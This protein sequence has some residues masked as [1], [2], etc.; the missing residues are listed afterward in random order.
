MLGLSNGTFD[1]LSVWDP[2]LQ[3]YVS[4]SDM[5]SRVPELEAEIESDA[6]KLQELGLI[7]SE[8]LD[9][10]LSTTPTEPVMNKI[11]HTEV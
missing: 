9:I 6:S 7:N 10:L 4:V 8:A 5:V 3:K 11:E 2:A 1:L